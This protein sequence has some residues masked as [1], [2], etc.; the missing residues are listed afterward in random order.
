MPVNYLARLPAKLI[1]E[2]CDLVPSSDQPVSLVVSKSLLP[3]LHQ[4]RYRCLRVDPSLLQSMQLVKLT[5]SKL[6]LLST[7]TAVIWEGQSPFYWQQ[8]AM[9]EIMP[10]LPSL[11]SIKFHNIYRFRAGIAETCLRSLPC[12]EKL[13]SLTWCP[14]SPWLMPVRA[15]GTLTSLTLLTVSVPGAYIGAELIDSLLS[16][17]LRC[18][19]F[20]KG[21]VIEFDE[22]RRIIEGPQKIASLRRITLDHASGRIGA[23]AQDFRLTQGIWADAAFDTL[24]PGWKRPEWRTPYNGDSIDNFVNIAWREGLAVNGTAVEAI[25]VEKAWRKDCALLEARL[26]GLRSD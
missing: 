3:F 10:H 24:L 17:P 22:L 18:L 6:E 5:K 16:L 26:R 8:L 20:L 25:E 14:N 21:C 2:I 9:S 12:P 13:W 7:T 19:S 4:A 1:Q 23:R 11:T 15:P